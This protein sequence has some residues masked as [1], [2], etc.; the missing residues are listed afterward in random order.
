MISIKIGLYNPPHQIRPLPVPTDSEACRAGTRAHFKLRSVSVISTNI[1]RA[2]L[3]DPQEQMSSH[4]NLTIQTLDLPASIYS[5]SRTHP[6]QGPNVHLSA[7]PSATRNVRLTR[8]TPSGG[9]LSKSEDGLR[10]A[11]AGT[12]CEPTLCL[13]NLG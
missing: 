9:S 11:V 4:W 10:C 2:E 7:N 13:L 5:D 3:P 6:P 8:A 1:Y 12:E